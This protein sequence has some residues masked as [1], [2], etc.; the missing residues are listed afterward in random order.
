MPRHCGGDA[1]RA[2]VPSLRGKC[3]AVPWIMPACRH[4]GFLN[5][6]S[7]VRILSGTPKSAGEDESE[8]LAR[9]LSNTQAHHGT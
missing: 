6:R 7:E 1:L 3:T 8:N 5:R 9:F 4:R 2:E